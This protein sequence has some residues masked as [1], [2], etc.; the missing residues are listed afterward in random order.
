MLATISTWESKK[1]FPRAQLNSGTNFLGAHGMKF[2]CEGAPTNQHDVL[3]MLHENYSFDVER[4]QGRSLTHCT[5][6]FP[7]IFG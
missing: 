1:K 2:Y 7:V 6:T 3:R 4:M 5:M